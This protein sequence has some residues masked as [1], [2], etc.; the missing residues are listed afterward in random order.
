MCYLKVCPFTKPIGQ[1]CTI[2]KR[3]DQC[4]PVITCPEVPVE[5]DVSV[6]QTT[7][8]L[9]SHQQ[10]GC[11]IDGHFYPEGAQMPGNTKKP[12]EL[13]YCIR[14]MT[15]CVMQECTLHVDGCRPIY[16]RGVCCPVRYDCA[17]DDE[18]LLIENDSQV[19]T[20]PPSQGFVITTTTTPSLPTDCIHNNIHYIDGELINTD[21]PCE[22]CYC[23]RGDIVCAVQE[24]GRP[25]EMHGKNCTARLPKEGECCPQVY[26][27]ESD[28]EIT[29]LSMPEQ[30]TSNVSLKPEKLNENIYTEAPSETTTESIDESE[31]EIH[32]KD[33]DHLTEKIRNITA[34]QM[35]GLEMDVNEET[36][37]LSGRKEEVATVM[38][39]TSANIDES[40]KF[41]TISPTINKKGVIYEEMVTESD[42]NEPSKSDMLHS[43]YTTIKSDSATTFG[44]ADVSQEAQ[45]M[46]SDSDG[47][48]LSNIIPGEGDCLDNNVSYTNNTNVP[49]R[50]KCELS[51]T[52][53][54]SIVVCE[55][56][57]CPEAIDLR[58]CDIVQ[59]KGACCPTYLC[60]NNEVLTSHP[61]NYQESDSTTEYIEHRTTINSVTQSPISTKLDDSPERESII[62]DEIKKPQSIQDEGHFEATT[63]IPEIHGMEYSQTTQSNVMGNRESSSVES[64]ESIYIETTTLQK[65]RFD[66]PSHPN[67]ESG[68]PEN[69]SMDHSP[70]SNGIELSTFISQYE[71]STTAKSVTTQKPLEIDFSTTVK[72]EQS[73]SKL[74]IEEMF[75]TL[76]TESDAESIFVSTTGH[77]ETTNV[78][79]DAVWQNTE[80]QIEENPSQDT[81]T[82]SISMDM[83]NIAPTT[84]KHLLDEFVID[85]TTENGPEIAEESSFNSSGERISDNNDETTVRNKPLSTE[86]QP[87]SSTNRD[88]NM[89][90]S[91]K[92]DVGE[93]EDEYKSTEYPE[94]HNILQ[95]I[96]WKTPP[97]VAIERD[98]SITESY[99]QELS[100]TTINQ[101]NTNQK[102]DLL[103]E[104]TVRT[105]HKSEPES[106]LS[107][108]FDQQSNGEMDFTTS[109][110]SKQTTLS[111][112]A[113]QADKASVNG[114]EPIQSV[115]S[116]N[117]S[118]ST[119]HEQSDVSITE[120]YFDGDNAI[121]SIP[122]KEEDLEFLTE[123]ISPSSQEDLE[124][125]TTE[126]NQNGDIPIESSTIEF[127][128]P[129]EQSTQDET[130][131]DTTTGPAQKD[132][133][134]N[135]DIPSDNTTQFIQ[136][137]GEQTT[138]TEGIVGEKHSESM[139]QTGYSTYPTIQPYLQTATNL[140]PDNTQYGLLT[141]QAPHFETSQAS[142][143]IDPQSINQI[144]EL[145]Q[146][147]SSK[148]SEH[149]TEK[150]QNELDDLHVDSTEQNL[151]DVTTL[152]NRISGENILTDV[153]TEF[154][155]YS[156]Q[157]NVYE[158]DNSTHVAQTLTDNFMNEQITQTKEPV[159]NSENEINLSK[160]QYEGST[161]PSEL[162]PIYD[163]SPRPLEQ[164]TILSSM[165][166][167]S[168]VLPDESSTFG[169]KVVFEGSNKFESMTQQTINEVSTTKQQNHVPLEINAETNTTSSVFTTESLS[170][171]FTDAT[172]TAQLYDESERGDSSVDNKKPDSSPSDFDVTT[173]RNVVELL[174]TIRPS[175]D[176]TV[177][178]STTEL[179]VDLNENTSLEMSNQKLPPE[180]ANNIPLIRDPK[181]NKSDETAT[182]LAESIDTTISPSTAI[183]HIEHVSDS[184][185]TENTNNELSESSYSTSESSLPNG[186]EMEQ[187]VETP[188]QQ[189][190]NYA[191]SQVPSYD[192]NG[193]G[194]MPSQYNDE[195]YTDEDE[196]TVFGPG[197]C[198]YG[199]KLYVSA[200][201]IPR[202][203]PCDFCFCFRSD[204]ICLQQSCPP[205][206]N[207]CHEEPIQ[208]FCC[209][210]YECPVSMGLVLNV[211]TTTTTTLPP[212]LSHFQRSS[213]KVSRSGCQVQGATYKIGERVTTAS[214]PC[215]DCVCGGDGQM[216]CDPKVCTPEPMLRQMIAVASS[217]R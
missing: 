22:H 84:V 103:D 72:E 101:E 97:P 16:N 214:G 74:P 209:P 164:S 57:R 125:V 165:Q 28:A 189:A 1:D 63:T 153:S 51:C 177:V 36:V 9:A 61:E 148:A 69:G 3:E 58:R 99:N 25:L 191:Q 131:T 143:I 216:K 190:P 44:M 205:P 94:K 83:G 17:H 183:S 121:Y 118:S 106:T 117:K 88:D 47:S 60:R 188:H 174:T 207:G 21:Q 8:D 70:Q 64:T 39:H 120:K 152:L 93:M 96:A 40:E 195:E 140:L 145:E 199:G 32:D 46:S 53:Y 170:Y 127:E 109:A 167:H 75:E 76:T 42:E 147:E 89:P 113:P 80:K 138:V 95:E 30:H 213:S 34:Q 104:S 151:I 124:I 5:L 196:P 65:N 13:C 166:D 54:N 197:T 162:T 142:N 79:V 86:T 91:E 126:K 26:E 172:T 169:Q 35:P 68:G 201:Q 139:H 111:P 180:S 112:I 149:T 108:I 73:A 157:G 24:C 173:I 87:D 185:A 90:S 78:P 193:Y 31:N 102:L 119:E 45:T 56:I 155:E 128:E 110:L 41:T 20:E 100:S 4:C 37:N 150:T 98:E 187:E 194:N 59:E 71:Y 48:Y 215:I 7:T 130:V 105:E 43:M 208:G 15:S 2:E 66:S 122:P 6:T 52:C 178:Y 82:N 115:Y 33:Y 158:M 210:R 55:K 27:C 182:K 38:A 181:P 176:N 171:A 198:R 49:V 14:N 179:N 85:T 168:T 154:E 11:S 186:I 211:T 133:D 156:T 129:L 81:A 203:D 107:P 161:N 23:M 77:S 135:D 217:R 192:Q 50:N 137:N 159:E 10:F 67:L 204:I 134:S 163:E 141:T 12:C 29:G 144:D 202:D 160:H 114:G 123:K 92:T 206:I 19:T 132:N 200:Q 62:L 184:E 175:Y 136:R 18:I 116:S 146:F 212:Y